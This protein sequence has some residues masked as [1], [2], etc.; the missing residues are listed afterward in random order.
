MA[1]HLNILWDTGNVD[2]IGIWVTADDGQPF[3]VLVSNET[4]GGT[5]HLTDDETLVRFKGFIGWIEF[6]IRNRYFADEASG[7]L[8]RERTKGAYMMIV[9]PD[10]FIEQ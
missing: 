7:A 3:L 10:D 6:G 5:D 9:Q 2:E 8:A 1:G 4:L